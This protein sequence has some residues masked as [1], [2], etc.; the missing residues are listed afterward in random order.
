MGNKNVGVGVWKHF[1]L[2]LGSYFPYFSVDTDTPI[3]KFVFWLR[4]ILVF[5][6]KTMNT[7]V[8]LSSWNI[9]RVAVVDTG[10]KVQL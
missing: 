3:S 5:E 7:D 4:E 1:I 6:N 8:M 2:L 9:W 10:R